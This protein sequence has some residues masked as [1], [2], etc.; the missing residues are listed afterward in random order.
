MGEI[1]KFIMFIG[2]ISS[3]FDYTTYCLMWFFFKCSN[4]ALAAPPELAAR[5]AQP[6]NADHSYAA[7]LVQHRLVC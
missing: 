1:A 4:L 2:P 5:F 6:I 3:I 7:A